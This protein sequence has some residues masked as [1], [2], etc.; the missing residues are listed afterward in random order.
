[1][2]DLVAVVVLTVP[3]L[4][5]LSL[6]IYALVSGWRQRR[7][8]RRGIM[9]AG[10]ASRAYVTKIVGPSRAGQATVYFS[11]QPANSPHSVV[12]KQRTTMA[13]IDTL[14]ITVGSSI[15]VSY[16]AKWPQWAFAHALVLS[17]RGL[18]SEPS[19][20][21]SL[22]PSASDSALFYVSYS[23]PS[24]RGSKRSETNRFGWYGSGD[25]VFADSAIRFTARRHWRRRAV[26]RKFPLDAIQNVEQ[27]QST[28]RFE[29]V[30]H[31][32]LT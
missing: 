28:V 16:I 14:G 8:D 9:E 3:T 31:G 4:L 27:L 24:R 17:E 18:P 12:G 5:V 11:L 6:L 13:A 25:V 22:A 2:R 1:M 21:G 23:D 32:K 20:R 10:T 29:I 7:Q 19:R 15:E 26:Q 30:E